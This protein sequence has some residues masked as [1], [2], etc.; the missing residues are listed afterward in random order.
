MNVLVEGCRA[1]GLEEALEDMKLD[2]AREDTEG[3]REST[4]EGDVQ[5]LI[6]C[7]IVLLVVYIFWDL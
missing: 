6:G 2:G 5:Q 7:L 1:G 3:W 4:P